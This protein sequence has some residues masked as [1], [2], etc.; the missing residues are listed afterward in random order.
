[1]PTEIVIIPWGIIGA[2]PRDRHRPRLQIPEWI[3]VS[4]REKPTTPFHIRERQNREKTLK[5]R[6]IQNIDCYTQ[7]QAP[8]QP[9]I[10]HQTLDQP[11][12]PVVQNPL[13]VS[14][15]LAWVENFIIIADEVLDWP[16]PPPELA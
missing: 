12:I 8:W 6:A 3:L 10:Y 1:M 14:H 5:P 15:E 7:R 13:M 9:K 11:E 16:R 2:E 4:R